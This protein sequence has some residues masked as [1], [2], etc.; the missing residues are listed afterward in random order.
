M[1]GAGSRTDGGIEVPTM[2]EHNNLLSFLA[3][4]D[5]YGFDFIDVKWKQGLDVLGRGGTAEVRELFIT[6]KKM[7]AY[8][9]HRALAAVQSNDPGIKRRNLNGGRYPEL[10]EKIFNEMVSEVT[11]LGHPLIRNHQNIVGLAGV[12]WELSDGSDPWPVLVFDKAH[13]GN[14]WS[15]ATSPEGLQMSFKDRLGICLDI[16][17]AISALHE[18]GMS[19]TKA[20]L[21]Y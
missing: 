3:I 15:F 21:L 19:H 5:Y 10:I 1:R 12:Y 17:Q 7:F 8:K 4:V 18:L 2:N 9:R 6:D 14:M 11:V 20:L 13:H 16:A